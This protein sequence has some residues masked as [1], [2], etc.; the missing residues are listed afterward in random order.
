MADPKKAKA[1]ALGAGLIVPGA[2]AKLS[3][4]SAQA[5][6]RRAGRAWP[7]E[8]VTVEVSE[9]S[10]AQIEQIMSEPM[11]IVEAL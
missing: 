8:A 7:A 11:L 3:I 5:G 1:P 4:R 6:F 9:F 2:A 10:E